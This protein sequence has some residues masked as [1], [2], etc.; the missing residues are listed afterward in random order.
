MTQFYATISKDVKHVVFTTAMAYIK[1]AGGAAGS[2]SDGEEPHV[3]QLA[4]LLVGFRE[5]EVD[6]AGGFAEGLK[7]C[8]WILDAISEMGLLFEGVHDVGLD[9]TLW[10]PWASVRGLRFLYRDDEFTADALQA[11]QE[12]DDVLGVE[13]PTRSI[14]T[15]PTKR[16][17]A[18]GRK[19]GDYLDTDEEE[20]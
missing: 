20:G 11:P 10:V 8:Q 13:S 9:R 16:E 17:T 3:V 2:G 7:E 1:S 5:V 19:P 14:P 15:S 6:Y 18:R 12:P 4:P